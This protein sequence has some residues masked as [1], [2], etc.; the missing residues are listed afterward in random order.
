M[1]PLAAAERLQTV[2]ATI[3]KGVPSH[4]L[5]PITH[6]GQHDFWPEDWVTKS[7]GEAAGLVCAVDAAERVS[8]VHWAT[9]H[10][11]GTLHIPDDPSAEAQQESV[12]D[13]SEHPDYS[14][15][16]GDVVLRLQRGNQ[17]PADP[18]NNDKEGLGG[19]SM[20]EAAET[21]IADLSVSGSEPS[22][23]SD[24][25]A[26]AGYDSKGAPMTSSS[27]VGEI[28]GMERGL[29]RVA[30]A[31]STISNVGPED[32]YVVGG[33]DDGQSSNAGSHTSDGSWE[34]VNSELE[35]GATNP[36][37]TA[38]HVAAAQWEATHA[39]MELENSVALRMAEQGDEREEDSIATVTAETA[40]LRSQLEAVQVDTASPPFEADAPTPTLLKSSRV[41]PVVANSDAVIPEATPAPLP[42]A[43]D[44]EDPDVP[45]AAIPSFESIAEGTDDHYYRE[46]LPGGLPVPTRAWQRGVSREWGILR[47][48][49][50]QGAMWIRCF[51][52][53]MDLLR[54]A[55]AGAPG[56]PYHNGLYIFDIRVP[57][58]FPDM[59]P[60]VHYHSF[61]FRI[62]PNLYE[63]G[64]VC[65]SLLGTWQG[66]GV[67]KWDPSSSTILQVLVSIQGL[68][69]IEKP[70]YNEAGYEK[71]QGSAQGEHN[72]KLY[73]ESAF[74]VSCKTMLALIR[75]PPC[76]FA[77]LVRA[78]FCVHGPRILNA[79]RLYLAGAAVGTLNAEC[80][81]PAIVQSANSDSVA[82]PGSSTGFRLMLA[83]LVPKLEHGIRPLTH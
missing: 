57:A 18:R 44:Y 39:D 25:T 4:E 77:T 24:E 83:K 23:Q 19:T 73:N 75:S 16:L 64:K 53:R 61:G 43:R 74:L 9:P 56:S 6:V 32:L 52:E 41:D 30:W 82:A 54:V 78:H 38:A 29:L 26:P 62:N 5:I 42:V 28:I 58:E 59:P 22:V 55:I 40:A 47:A 79:C 51:E 37:D 60:E 21:H 1:D 45:L 71:Q 72:A 48:G 49:A 80:T 36:N 7:D 13:L 69:L 46:H 8:I 35:Q 14:F 76:H 67:E 65:L 3:S 68:V 63:C 20:T 81:G 15:R 34:T 50:P 66:E 11:N 2:E 33:D 70:Y 31:D 10:S 12:Y 27:W 17:I